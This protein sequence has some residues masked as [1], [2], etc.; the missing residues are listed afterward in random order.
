M[1]RRFW[2]NAKTPKTGVKKYIPFLNLFCKNRDAKIPDW[3]YVIV[4]FRRSPKRDLTRRVE[5]NSHLLG[6]KLDVLWSIG[7]RN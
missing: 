5:R 7:Y 4:K 2:Q 1:T 6:I 3:Y